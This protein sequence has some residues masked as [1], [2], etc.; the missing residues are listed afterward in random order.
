MNIVCAAPLVGERLLQIS[1]RHMA[2][3]FGPTMDRTV[4]FLLVALPPI[5][6]A[7]MAVLPRRRE[8]RELQYGIKGVGEAYSR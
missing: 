1:A 2:A 4:G 7:S 5:V 8:C 3:F 6:A